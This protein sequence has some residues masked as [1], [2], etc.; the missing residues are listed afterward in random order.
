[1]IDGIKTEFKKHS[2]FYFGRIIISV[3]VLT[4]FVYCSLRFSGYFLFAVIIAVA[5]YIMVWIYLSANIMEKTA[6]KIQKTG[7]SVDW[8]CSDGDS[9]L[10]IDTKVG[11]IATVWAS[12]PFKIQVI[13][14]SLLTNAKVTL[15]RKLKKRK[16]T[17]KIGIEYTIGNK[18][19]CSYIYRRSKSYVV[20]ASEEGQNYVHK[21][22]KICEM[23]LKA[24][25]TAL[26]NIQELEN[27][28]TLGRFLTYDEVSQVSFLLNENRK[29]EAIKLVKDTTRLGLAESKKIVDNWYIIHYR[30]SKIYSTLYT[31]YTDI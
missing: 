30:I 16:T 14:A 21:A 18:Q 5:I 23:L 13:D 25:E 29:I 15:G 12:N 17:N 31:S 4:I 28:I 3:I 19:Y 22:N 24:K 10:M 2:L 9:Y 1:M 8:W 27:D 11:Q 7:F 6:T 20:L 26:Q